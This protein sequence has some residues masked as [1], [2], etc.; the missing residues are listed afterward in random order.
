M[1]KKRV[2]INQATLF[3]KTIGEIDA[4]ERKKTAKEE[5]EEE[6]KDID[7]FLVDETSLFCLQL[8]VE[9]YY[10]TRGY[11]FLDLMNEEAVISLGAPK[12]EDYD[13]GCYERSSQ[14]TIEFIKARLNW[15]KEYLRK[16][17][18]TMV[19]ESAEPHYEIFK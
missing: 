3:G 15:A 19:E 8:D 9:R 18:G 13:I 1:R 11:W 5:I 10:G 16:I 12:A 17:L 7:Y 2:T 6:L 14:G 4:T